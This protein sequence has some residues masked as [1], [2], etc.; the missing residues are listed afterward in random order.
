MGKKLFEQIFET[1]RNEYIESESGIKFSCKILT[2]SLND[3]S[4]EIEKKI[5]EIIGYADRYYYM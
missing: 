5:A 1:G 4:Q 2:N 3:T